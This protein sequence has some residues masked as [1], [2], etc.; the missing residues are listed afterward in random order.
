MGFCAVLRWKLCPRALKQ[1]PALEDFNFSTVE[2]GG[3]QKRLISVRGGRNS[4]DDHSSR[5]RKGD[6]DVEIVGECGD[7]RR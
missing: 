5:E 3:R 6:S 1:P 2:K 4:D 7:S